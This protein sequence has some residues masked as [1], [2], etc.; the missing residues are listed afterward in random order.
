MRYWPR[1]AVLAKSFILPDE[2]IIV[3]DFDGNGAND[4]LLYRPSLGTFRMFTRTDATQAV[5][6]SFEAMSGFAP[7]GLGNG[8]FVN[9]QLR[10]GQWGTIG[11]RTG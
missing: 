8:N 7:G 4:F 1:R 2:K 9:F 6:Q 5:K 11:G 10:A 3:G